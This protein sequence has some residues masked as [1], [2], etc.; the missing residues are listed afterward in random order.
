MNLRYCDVPWGGND[1]RYLE[2]ICFEYLQTLG[3]QWWGGNYEYA[4]GLQKA[5]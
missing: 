3:M 1:R 2:V 4:I 5:V